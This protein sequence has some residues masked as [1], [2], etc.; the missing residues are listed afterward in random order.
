[1]VGDER[2]T[3]LPGTPTHFTLLLRALD[4]TLHHVDTLRCAVSA[5]A[6]LP[7]SLAD[8]MYARLGVEILHVYGCS[9]GFLT[10][11]TE[12][13]A[14]RAGSAGSRVFRGP[15]GT[16]PDGTVVVLDT[17]SDVRLPVGSIGEIAY[18]AASPVRYWAEQP[19]ATNGWYRT[20]DLGFIDSR[21]RV[22]VRGRLKEVINRGGLKVAC[23]E[24]AA[25]LRGLSS[26]EDCVVIPSP[27][28]V[29]GEAICACV[30]PAR[31]SAPTIRD[32]RSQ[33]LAVLARHKLPDELCLLG[34]IPHTSLGK[35][36]SAALTRRIANNELPRTRFRESAPAVT[37]PA[38]RQG[39]G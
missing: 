24:V 34:S 30:V 4:P 10:A 36:D 17:D 8:E 2:V 13:D 33:L 11:T 7:T 14:I 28:P 12:R 23:S 18:G 21:G 16:A 26:V 39:A 9:E 22:F 20:G 3:V 32:L 25:A 27:D 35:I 19:A 38:P 6:P 15:P 5:A 1:M 29:L 31:G 37:G